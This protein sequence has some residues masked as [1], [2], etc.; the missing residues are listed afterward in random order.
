MNIRCSVVQSISWLEVLGINNFEQTSVSIN[1]I[2]MKTL[3]GL[4]KDGLKT[5]GK[6]MM[7]TMFI[8]V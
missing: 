8:C 7:L 6:S 5:S 3:V 2:D 4:N 1:H